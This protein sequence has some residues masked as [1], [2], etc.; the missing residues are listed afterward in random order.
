MT[1]SRDRLLDDSL[2]EAGI[3]EAGTIVA[4]AARM[5]CSPA[6]VSARLTRIRM[7]RGAYESRDIDTV[8]ER[9][10]YKPTPAQVRALLASHGAEACHERWGRPPSYLLKQ[11]RA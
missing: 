11:A 10:R 2:I 9:L 4:Y 6:L 5:G 7:E 3:A 1:F 8:E